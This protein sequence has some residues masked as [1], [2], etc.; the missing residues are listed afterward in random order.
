MCTALYAEIRSQHMQLLNDWR[1]EVLRDGD[2]SYCRT[3]RKNVSEEP[4]EFLYGMP[5]IQEKIL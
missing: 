2:R 4:A 3:G 1:D 5:Q